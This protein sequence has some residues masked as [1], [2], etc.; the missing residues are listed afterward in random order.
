M[1][2]MTEISYALA[3][4]ARDGVQSLVDFMTAD[5]GPSRMRYRL[6]R[7][8]RRR[9]VRRFVRLYVPALAVVGGLVWLSSN[10]T[11]YHAVE[12]RAEAMR[13]TVA[14]R[15]EFAISS[16]EVVG[17]TSVVESEI[18]SR[19]DP[20]EDGRPVS[21]LDVDT[22]ALRR[23]VERLGWVK[24]ARVTLMPP[25]AIRI[26]VEERVPAAV[27][28]SA[29]R[30]TLIDPAGAEI[31]PLAQR[32]EWSELPLVVGPDAAENVAEA[33]TLLADAVDLT[34]RIVG[35]VRVGER[36]WDVHLT[37][38]K[39]LMLPA[40]KPRDALKRILLLHRTEGLLDRDVTVVDYRAPG[41]PTVRLG[42]SAQ[43]R[44]RELRD[45][46]F[47]EETDA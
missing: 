27:W 30:V 18:L 22:A 31:E 21:S 42:P 2:P 37:E 12:E 25:D 20:G 32:S 34:P 19:F 13:A 45:P 35:F 46:N 24:S 8:W 39:V 4:A 16:V 28:R 23:E 6:N 47:V 44:L 10:E 15:P 5:G 43:D 38:G 3:G 17:A 36:R 1:R 11:L 29:G 41:R 33:L 14:Q 9:S 7:L 26:D 40:D